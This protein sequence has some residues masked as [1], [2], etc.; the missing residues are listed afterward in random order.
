MTRSLRLLFILYLESHLRN[1]HEPSLYDGENDYQ[2]MEAESKV[3]RMAQVE[4]PE[5]RLEVTI[6]FFFNCQMKM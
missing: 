5:E 2:S 6:S 3:W 4:G 1:R